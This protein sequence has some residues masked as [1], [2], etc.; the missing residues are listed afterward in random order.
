MN[1]N[2]TYKR[3]AGEGNLQHIKEKEPSEGPAGFP[4]KPSGGYRERN[5][6]KSNR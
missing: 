1:S 5:I 4:G 3:Y 2:K 6:V